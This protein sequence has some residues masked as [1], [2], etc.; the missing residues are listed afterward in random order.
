MK[1]VAAA[2]GGEAETLTT[3][4]RERGEV[5]H[6]WPSFLPG[7][8]ALLFTISYAVRGPEI[9][10][11]NLET[12]VTTVLLSGLRARYLPSGHLVFG[13]ENTLR[14][15]AFDLERLTVAGE[16][17]PVVSPVVAVAGAGRVSYEYDV[18]ADG[19]LVYLLDDHYVA[20]STHAG[21]GRSAGT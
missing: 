14:A 16:P 15:V 11:L 10:V 13:T 1:R 21:L 12:G 5:R 6:S 3:P 4:D 8:R 9:A 19:T 7:G 17:V 20:V 18:A 2:S